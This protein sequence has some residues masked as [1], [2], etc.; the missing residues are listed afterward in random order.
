MH[1]K[2]HS[3]GDAVMQTCGSQHDPWPEQ[4]LRQLDGCERVMLSENNSVVPSLAMSGPQPSPR[5]RSL[6]DKYGMPDTVSSPIPIVLVIITI[7]T[8]IY[9]NNNNNNNEIEI[10]IAINNCSSNKNSIVS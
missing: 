8:A 6:V 2:D 3:N 1:D 9:N 5:F 10:I 7:T 4:P